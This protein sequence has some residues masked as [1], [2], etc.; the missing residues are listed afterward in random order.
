V[1]AREAAVEIVYGVHPVLEIL[2]ARPGEVERVFVARDGGRGLG[3]AL[4]LAR[5]R[6]VPVTHL[7]R[8]LL[9][10]KVGAGAVHQGIAAQVAPLAYAD[11]EA[12]CRKATQRESGLLVFLDRVVDPGNLGAILR[13]CAGAGVDGVVL[14]GKSSVGLTGIVAKASAGAIERIPVARDPA[15]ADRVLALR[16]SGFRAYALSPRGGVGWQVPDYRGR[17]IFVAGGEERGPRP[18]LESA[19]D[20]FIT[21]PLAAGVESL[22][23][24]VALGVVLFEALRQRAGRPGSG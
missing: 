10:R 16:D 11:V 6:G 3:R 15:P 22:N 13:T 1:R 23:V 21:L 19:C 12:V 7:P 17:I 20:S 9:R 24:A 14:G 18:K 8:E 5:E 2:D 4:R